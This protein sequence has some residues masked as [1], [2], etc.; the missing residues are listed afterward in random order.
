MFGSLAC[1]RCPPPKKIYCQA[2]GFNDRR[3]RCKKKSHNLKAFQA[4]FFSPKFFSDTPFGN[5]FGCGIRGAKGDWVQSRISNIYKARPPHKS[6]NIALS[7]WRS[8]LSSP[9]R[10]LLSGFL[11]LSGNKL[12][13]GNNLR[14]D[15]ISVRVSSSLIAWI[16]PSANFSLLPHRYWTHPGLNFLENA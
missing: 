1:L 5:F 10:F 8:L 16:A 2:Q 15:A 6:G 4:D 13:P 12:K 7:C 9:M 14:H 11:K 3:Y